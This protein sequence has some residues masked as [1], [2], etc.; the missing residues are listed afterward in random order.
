[1]ITEI[2]YIEYRLKEVFNLNVALDCF[3]L[4]R[5][6]LKTDYSI[7]NEYEKNEIDIEK[8]KVEISLSRLNKELTKKV[9]E[10]QDEIL[11]IQYA[12]ENNE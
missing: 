2:S 1:M 9:K 3:Y 6:L 12:Q 4:K 10:L 8:I 11:L 7:L 5:E